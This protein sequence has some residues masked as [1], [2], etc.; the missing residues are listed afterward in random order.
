MKKPLIIVALLLVPALLIASGFYFEKEI[1]SSIGYVLLIFYIVMAV[2]GRFSG[3][4]KE[5]E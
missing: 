3:E 4:K 5:Q 2:R 1:L